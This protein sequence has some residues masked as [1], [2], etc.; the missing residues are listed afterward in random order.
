M[1]GFTESVGF[2]VTLQK[3]E[4]EDDDGDT[5]T[6]FILIPTALKALYD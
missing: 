5:D 6:P 3:D 4:R 1:S 2:I